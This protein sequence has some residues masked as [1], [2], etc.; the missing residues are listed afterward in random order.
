[1][2]QINQLV[3]FSLA[4]QGYAVPLP[5]VQRVVH[6]AEVAPLPKAPE[7]VLGVI[8]FAGRVIPVVDLRLRFSL[9][10]KETELYDFLIIARTSRRELAFLADKVAGVIDCPDEELIS[11][12]KI[13][14]GLES[15]QGVMRLQ[16][17]LIFIHDL[18]HFLSLD[19]EKSL[20]EAVKGLGAS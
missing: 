18:D 2:S 6:V 5:Q 17:G 14:P 9:P 4:G 20:T 8:N 7:V 12:A 3:E 15:L 11:A 13:V 1:M 16:D 19:E 10:V